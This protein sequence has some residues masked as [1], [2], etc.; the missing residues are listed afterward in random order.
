MTKRVTIK[1][2]AIRLNISTATVSRVL[3]N[4]EDPYISQATK[5]KVKEAAYS[6]GYKKNVIAKALAS[7][8]TNII[9]IQI[10]VYYTEINSY[11]I[12]MLIK[13]GY[14]IT[15][16][17]IEAMYLRDTSFHID[18]FVKDGTISIIHGELLESL[19]SNPL[20]SN[21]V[22][23]GYRY[24]KKF[25]HVGLSFYNGTRDAIR[26]LVKTG[27]KRI[28]YLTDDI[29]QIDKEE[30]C[31]AYSDVLN[32]SGLEP[33]F[34]TT[35]TYKESDI[36]DDLCGYLRNGLKIDALFCHSDGRAIPAHKAILDCG[37]KIPDDISVIGCD[38]DSRTRFFTPSI[39]TIDI[40]VSDLCETSWLF[41]KNRI[42]DN[43]IPI[44][45]KILESRLLL[46][47]STR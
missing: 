6:M 7:G 27:C 40:D 18:D 15:F 25:D 14:Q 34:I 31:R 2:I 38:N 23:I 8:R 11:Y 37:Y 43:S 21:F 41:L 30:R 33:I 10:P 39:S 4:V 46:R 16:R 26:H 35:K 1:D 5:D 12:D 28:G 20:S 19:I 42:E 44:Q 24:S 17:D 9:E 13:D 29:M 47:E 22:S 45:S 32:D 36:Y 3:G